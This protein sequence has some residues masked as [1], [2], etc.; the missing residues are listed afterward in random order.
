[1]KTDQR[2]AT[3]AE[4]RQQCFALRLTGCTYQAIADQVGVSRQAC[5]GLVKRELVRLTLE[6]EKD[7]SEL[8]ALE[9]ERL[10]SLT[11]A[12]WE[13]ALGGDLGAVDRLLKI[14]ERRARFLGLDS[15]VQ[16]A[17]DFLSNQVHVYVPDN[18]RDKLEP[19]GANDDESNETRRDG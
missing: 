7:A 11:Q 1:M 8:R 9:L 14:S 19:T 6:T 3:A 10:D 4:R 13:K 5:H 12:C 15:P 17:I 2:S 16:T 18:G